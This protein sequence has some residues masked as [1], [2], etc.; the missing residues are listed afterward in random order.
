MDDGYIEGRGV[1]GRVLES[2]SMATVGSIEGRAAIEVLMGFVQVGAHDEEEFLQF[3]RLAQKETRVEAHAVQLPVVTA[4]DDDDGSLA[5]AD[6][7]AQ[8]F[9]EGSPIKVGQANIQQDEM[10]WKLGYGAQ[11]LLAVREEGK[12]PVG[13]VLESVAK[14]IS[15]FGVIF[16]DDD[17]FGGQ[18]CL[19]RIVWL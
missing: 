8:H 3:E 15:K 14:E 18:W 19:R 17:M 16:D 12:L 9:V 4:S 1:D 6:V 11:S 5:G 10:S 13:I 2:V 7:A